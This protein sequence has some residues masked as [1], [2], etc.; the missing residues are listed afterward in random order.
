MTPT[1]RWHER[2]AALCKCP[3]CPEPRCSARHLW[4]EC[5]KFEET[6]TT[7]GLKYQVPP[8]WWQAQPRALAKS[9][10]APRGGSVAQLIAANALGVAV[11]RQGAAIAAA[12]A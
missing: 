1:R 11:A 8:G 4:A 9:G 3:W 6:R 5:P 7:L 10:W 2:D 12:W